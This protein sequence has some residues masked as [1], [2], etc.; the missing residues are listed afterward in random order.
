MSRLS[1]DR[2]GPLH[3]LRDVSR[4]SICQLAD[5]CDDDPAHSAHVARLAVQLFDALAPLHGLDPTAREYLEAGA[6]LANVG[7]VVAH[8]KHHLHAYYVIR[9]SELAGL[10]DAEIEVI[11][12]IARYHRKSAPKPSH[13]DFAALPPAQQDLVRTL[14]AILRVAI[15]LDRSHQAQ[16]C[17]VG[18][19]L[20]SDQVVLDVESCA[21]AD[22]SLELYAANERKELLETVLGRRIER[23]PRAVRHP[24]VVDVVRGGLVGRGTVVVV[25]VVV[26]GSGVVGDSVGGTVGSTVVG[27]GAIVV[28]VVVVVV[29]TVLNGGGCAP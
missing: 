22:V 13:P 28:V 17:H 11:A 14:A 27:G 16:V 4:R 3:H 23:R 25:D 5:R 18:A 19:D 12:Q 10:T 8:S 1:G 21:G 24:P 6:L 7:L 15:G 20:D 26:A 9:N 29:S 2:A